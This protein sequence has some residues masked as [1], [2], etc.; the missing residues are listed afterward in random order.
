MQKARRTAGLSCEVVRREG[1][2]PAALG[3]KVR[4]SRL[5]VFKP[6]IFRLITCAFARTGRQA[7]HLVVHKVCSFAQLLAHAPCDTQI[8]MQSVTFGLSETMRFLSLL[9]GLARARTSFL[10]N[11]PPP[12][13]FPF[14]LVDV[15]FCMAAG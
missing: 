13:I 3:L 8:I 4:R 1:I 2:E 14:R 7:A 5:L 15:T 9:T 6:V 11:G 12:I 10:G